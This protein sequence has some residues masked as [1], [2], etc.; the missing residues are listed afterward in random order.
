VLA[1]LRLWWT[2]RREPR[3]SQTITATAGL[4]I[5]GNVIA[6]P[7]TFN[8]VDN[9][10]V[11]EVLAALRAQV[12][13]LS[14]A[15]AAPDAERRVSEAVGD[16]A[17]GAAEGDERLQQA[18][19]LLR[20]GNVTAAVPLLQAVAEEKTARIRQDSAVAAA[21]YRNLGAIAGLADP[22]KAR[23]AYAEAARLDPDH[24]VGAFWHGWF[25]ADAGNLARAESAYARVISLAKPGTDDWALYGAQL[26]LGDARV[27]RGDL[28]AATAEYER[29]KAIAERLARSDPGNAGWQR[30]LSVSFDRVADVL[31]AQGNLPEALKSYRDSLAIRDRLA[32][33]DPGNALWQRD[34]SVSFNKVGDVLVAQ[35]N[36]PEALKSYRDSL[37][38]FDRLAQ[39]DPGNAGWQR[40]LALSYGR[41]G[42][43]EAR[44]GAHADALIA[45]KKGRGIA[46]RLSRQSPDNAILKK[47]L[48]WFDTQIAA[49]KR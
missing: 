43:V 10:E 5:G 1:S 40:D 3:D 46:V 7:I 16:I 44:R 35:G 37:T 8:Q 45:M 4:A 22:K 34:L 28:T 17:R 12:A 33:S 24:I 2:S 14:P 38:I 23:A 21:A 25:E 48:M 11:L 36:L 31:V 49:L 15:Q 18:L 6:S 30:D 20:A 29:G 41:V 32:Q 39:S 13:A 19:D 26:G 47:D 27:A 42:M 9:A